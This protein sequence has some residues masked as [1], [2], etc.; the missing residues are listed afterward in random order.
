MKLLLT[1]LFFSMISCHAQIKY[2][3]GISA[4]NRDTNYPAVDLPM[5]STVQTR[6][7]N[8]S[9]SIKTL[10]R[11]AGDLEKKDVEKNKMIVEQD[12]TINILRDSIASISIPDTTLFIGGNTRTTQIRPH[13]QEV[14]ILK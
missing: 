2:V 8:Q 1:I 14:E 11:W 12:K 10:W 9:D 13:Y 4:K 5:T 6:F 7:K 3:K